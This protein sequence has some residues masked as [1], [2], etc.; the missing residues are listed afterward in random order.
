M[1]TIVD[2][3][4]GN[5]R[6]VQKAF[7]KI[8]AEARL[9]DEPEV[10]EQIEQSD[11]LV[12]PGVGAFDRAVENLQKFG[13][14]EPIQAHL[15]LEKP[16]LGICLGLQLLFEQSEEGERQGFARYAGTVRKF[17]EKDVRLVPHMGWNN[18]RWGGPGT[19]FA[20]ENVQSPSYYFVHSF[21]PDP[22]DDSIIAG[23]TDYGSNFCS[24]I[25]EN[26]TVGVQFHPEKSQYAG[27]N[28][29]ETITQTLIDP[30]LKN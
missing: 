9:S 28:L 7:E 15:E 27:L 23:T 17:L 13:L 18:V 14:W 8:G 1:I 5:L 24:A 12:V 30:A 25:R 2:Y 6:S 20:P 19:E 3:G 11:L 21:Y 26:N 16:Y 4:M 22:E 29:L 10:I